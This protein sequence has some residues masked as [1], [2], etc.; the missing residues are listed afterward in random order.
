MTSVGGCASAEREAGQQVRR[1]NQAVLERVEQDWMAA[2]LSLV[3]YR[4]LQSSAITAVNDGLLFC[5]CLDGDP[6]TLPV[7]LNGALQARRA[8]APGTMHVLP[9]GTLFESCSPPSERPTTYLNI[10][11]PVAVL[12]EFA[13]E[14]RLGALAPNFDFHDPFVKL[15]GEQML[16][17]LRSGE[18]SRIYRESASRVMAANLLDALGPRK[19]P[20]ASGGLASR[21]MRRV[22]DFVM[23]HLGD[24][25]GLPELAAVA[26]LSPFHFCRAFKQST[27]LSPHAWVTARRV[28]RAQT[29][30]RAHPGMGLA[31]IALCVGYQSQA[32]FG[33]AFK[34]ETG[35]TPGRWRR[36][37]EG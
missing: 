27:G 23:D 18:E 11:F 3:R 30:M 10:A 32:A 17:R 19:R 12:E 36:D 8:I 25:I 13:D 28:E 20:C 34:R 21:Q 16:A 37:L 4:R 6:G 2:Q 29:L 31:E 15:L 14:H 33:T 24:D 35:A 26:E 5:F 1:A 7:R 9:P 22:R